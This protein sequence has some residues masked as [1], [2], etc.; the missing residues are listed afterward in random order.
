MNE[1][2]PFLQALATQWGPMG[3]LVAFLIWRD[4]RDARAREALDKEKG[5]QRA[6]AE[7]RRHAYDR[8]RL[9]CDRATAQVL[10]ALTAVIQGLKR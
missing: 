8:E 4:W 6:R 5:E 10:G 1:A 9:E 3:L 2:G 7:E